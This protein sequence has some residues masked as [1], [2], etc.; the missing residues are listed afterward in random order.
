MFGLEAVASLLAAAGTILCLVKS[1]SWYEGPAG[2]WPMVVITLASLSVISLAN[3]ALFGMCIRWTRSMEVIRLSGRV[4]SIVG[5]LNGLPLVVLQLSGTMVVPLQLSVLGQLPYM[6]GLTVMLLA[7]PVSGVVLSRSRH[8]NLL[9]I[10][11][12]A[13]LMGMF[14]GTMAFM[15]MWIL[16]LAGFAS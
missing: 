8:E 6:V 1:S 12:A 5:M 3:A 4:H 15:L 11:N 14:L 9:V 13:G 2:R 16:A 7:L 10:S